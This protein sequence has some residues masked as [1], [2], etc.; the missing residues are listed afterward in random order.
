MFVSGLL[1]TARA[2]FVYRN[3]HKGKSEHTYSLRD[4]STGKVTGHTQSL[5]L[6]DPVFKVSG[7]GRDRVRREGVKNV[8]AGVLG[9]VVAEAPLGAE[10][11]RVTYDPKK[12]QGFVTRDGGKPVEKAQYAK[13]TPSGVE[14]AGIAEEYGSE[15]GR[16][17]VK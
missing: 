2:L 10:W 5:I 6:K 9:T 15:L 13:L 4:R 7:K 8:H 11:F 14:V 12:N 1:K 16:G 3:V 17:A